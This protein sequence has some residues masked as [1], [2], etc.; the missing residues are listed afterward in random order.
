MSYFRETRCL[1]NS[2][3]DYLTTS[4]NADW[5]DVDVVK[6]F[7]EVYSNTLTVPIVCV[8]VINDTNRRRELGAN[9]L[10]VEYDVMID[11]F[12][13]SDSQRLDLADY[14]KDKLKDGCT[15]Y[16]YSHASGDKET[17]ETTAAG[18][19][20][21]LRINTNGRVELYTDDLDPKDRYRHSMSIT[22]RVSLS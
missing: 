21:M 18:D 16:T 8:R 7:K 17:L 10:W 15:Y 4:F 1:E 11:I 19:V 2:I 9:T 20:F 5:S 13:R 6:T 22:F 14:V 12:A 3:I